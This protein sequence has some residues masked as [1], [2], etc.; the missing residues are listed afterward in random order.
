MSGYTLE[1]ENLTVAFR[2]ELGEVRPVEGLTFAVKPG[3]TLCIVGES[4]SGKTVAALS[5]LRLLGKNGGIRAGSVRLNGE[6]LTRKSETEMRSIRGRDIAMIFQEPMVSLNPVFTIGH[7]LTEAIRL[8]TD[9][10]GKA[11]KAHAVEMLRRVGIPR[12]EAVYGEYPHTLSGGMRQRAMIAMAVACEPRL[13]I[14]DEPTTALDVTVQA[15]IL[16]LMKR[17]AA[18]SGTSIVLITHDLGVVAE[19]ADQVAVMYAGQ[20][21]E[22]ADVYSLFENPLHPYTRGLMRSLPAFGSERE[23]RLSAIPGAVPPL[24]RLPRGCRFHPRCPM[25]ESI[26]ESEEPEL[27]PAEVSRRVRCWAASGEIRRFAGRQGG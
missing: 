1:V 12:P 14:A 17:L 10:R 11:A 7:Q 22:T 9:R 16:E 21:V 13:L 8:H 23:G 20:I 3:E 2:T 26:C 24:S 19:M 15:Q 18:G 5:L 6:E 25:A 4:G 27:Q